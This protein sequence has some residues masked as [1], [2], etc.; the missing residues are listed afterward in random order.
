MIL[1]TGAG[2]FKEA[3]KIGTEVYHNLKVRTSSLIFNEITLIQ[4]DQHVLPTG[5]LISQ[6]LHDFILV[7]NREVIT[8]WRHCGSCA[9]AVIKKKYGQDA[10]NVGDEGGFAPNIQ[11]WFMVDKSEFVVWPGIGT[12]SNL[13]V[14]IAITLFVYFLVF[15]TALEQQIVLLG[16]Q[17]VVVVVDTRGIL[18][19]QMCTL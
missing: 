8:V 9:Q 14:N 11:V 6:V 2:S 1:P 7:C 18:D 15:I 5:K 4:I 3:M 13:H 16:I 10:T 19:I 12:D 17:S